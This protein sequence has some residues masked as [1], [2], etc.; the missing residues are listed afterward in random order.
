MDF[1]FGW[2]VGSG[3]QVASSCVWIGSGEM[4]LGFNGVF[5]ELLGF[6]VWDLGF[7]IWGLGIGEKVGAGFCGVWGLGLGLRWLRKV[8]V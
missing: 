5:G 6:G 4:G 3:L 2:S 7:G 1:G 8:W